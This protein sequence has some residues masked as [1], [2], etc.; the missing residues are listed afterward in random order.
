MRFTYKLSIMKATIQVILCVAIMSLCI[1]VGY[2]LILKVIEK[3]LY[4]VIALLLILFFMLCFCIIPLYAIFVYCKQYKPLDIVK[5]G[6][7]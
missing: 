4:A 2:T 3:D 7:E 5:N 6:K 1:K